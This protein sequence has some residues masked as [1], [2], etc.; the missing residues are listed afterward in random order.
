M[1]FLERAID[2]PSATFKRPQ[3]VV[4]CDLS[5]EEKIQVLRRWEY[6]A[7]LLEVAQEENMTS[8]QPGVLSE[9]LTALQTLGAKNPVSAPTKSGGA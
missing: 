9:I 2:N 5:R 7:R 6:D 3:D 1:T 8:S 4:S